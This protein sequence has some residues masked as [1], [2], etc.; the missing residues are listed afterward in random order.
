[1]SIQFGRWNFDER[2]VDADYFGRI[3]S[4]LS[5][6]QFDDTRC[7]TKNKIKILHRSFYTT[8]ESRREVQPYISPSG[9]VLTWD[10]RLDN[11]PEV[12][13]QI[14]ETLT[15]GSTDIEIVAAIYEK[16]GTACFAKLIGDWAIAVWDPK[17]DSLILAK[18]HVGSRHLYY[19]FDRAQVTW[20][21]ILD[22]LV[23]LSGKTFE[24]NREYVAGWLGSLPAPDL[25]PYVGIYSV[26]PSSF[27]TLQRG[28]RSI[29]KYWDF[30]PSKR[31]LYRLDDEYEEH[32]RSVFKTAVSRRLRSDSIVL[33][34][35]SGGMDSSSIVCVADS[36]LAQGTTG[37]TGLNT[38]SYFDDSE[39]NW[40]ELPYIA[41]VEEARGHK[42]FHIDVGSDAKAFFDFTTETFAP[43][44]GFENSTVTEVR[45]AFKQC[46][47]SGG[48]RVVLSGFGGDEVMGGVPNPVPELAD[49]LTRLKLIRFLR[50]LHAWALHTRKPA[51]HLLGG[52]VE[53]F[54]PARWGGLRDHK[55]P[56]WLNAE[57][58][59]RHRKALQGYEYPLKLFGPLPSIQENLRTFGNLTREMACSIQP[60]EAM[61]EKRYPYLDR[62]LLE[63]LY[64]IPKAQIARPGQRR[65]L[66]R[67]AL[68]GIVPDE[69]LNRKRKAFV[70]RAPLV[71]LSREANAISNLS[72]DM[73]AAHLELVNSELF[74]TAVA[75]AR[76][77]HE[78]PI[79]F[80]IRTISLE[81][82]LRSALKQ[83]ALYI[84]ALTFRPSVVSEGRKSIPKIRGS[85]DQGPRMK[86]VR[87]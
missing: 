77:G 37:A 33:A 1:M 15:Q 47:L 44:P 84:S 54:F 42:G 12:T 63:F 71:A 68:R 9:I 85:D 72:K 87:V 64:S 86:K 70:A 17:N 62:N 55:A 36:I 79:V 34:E 4:F 27:V 45:K 73:I 19:S 49:L 5:T 32:F 46:L 53:E 39:P 60:A 48:H 2:P 75:S 74:S 29:H 67:R 76:A 35:L 6:Y 22:P 30:D 65:S 66:M 38:V 57:F 31:I 23:L 24:L 20:S 82:W 11:R 13:R 58:A 18:D 41:K 61:Y 26:P 52:I 28:R 69:L 21:T 83:G 8:E 51:L 50:Q 80:L 25:T 56:Q 7:Y 81:Y 16:S 10:G 14:E 78:I 40:D 43:L 59:A 3:E